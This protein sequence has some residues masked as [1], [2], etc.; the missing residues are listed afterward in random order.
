[1]TSTPQAAGAQRTTFFGKYRGTVTDNDDPHGQARIRAEVP[2][3]LPGVFTGWALPCLPYTGDDSGLH[4]VPP[5]GAGV[6]VEFEGGDPDYPIWSG[7]WWGRGQAPSAPSGAPARPPVKVLRSEQGLTVALDDGDQTITVSDASGTNILE[8][9]AQQGRVRLEAAATAVVEAPRIELVDNAAH[10]V[11]LGDR[12]LSYL[13]QLVTTFNVHL[14]AG[15]TASGM[16][17]VT[18]A[19]PATPVSP[20]DPGLL[21]T[22]VSSG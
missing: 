20:P 5:V 19:P 7:G 6:W 1:M 21:S 8:I 9:R 10:P 4:L 12:L 17:P 18:P 13:T 14:H 22:R 11:V 16:L 2:A 3:V 15:E